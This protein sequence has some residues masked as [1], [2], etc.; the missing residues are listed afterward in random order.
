M[1][2]PLEIR[3]LIVFDESIA[4]YEIHAHQPYASSG[5]NNNNE[6]HIA[7]QHQDQC[8]LPSQ[9]SLHIIGKV[10]QSDRTTPITPAN[11]TVINNFICHLFRE[12][13]YEINAIEIDRCKNVGITGTMK[14]YPSLD[15]NQL[16]YLK[17]AGWENPNILNAK[18]EFE[19]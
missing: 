6:I 3:A 11:T 18:E 10:T 14:A 4:L 15:Q 17:I 19:A 7:I 2:N 16:N 13:R 1:E 9:C 8:L 12:I 5:Y